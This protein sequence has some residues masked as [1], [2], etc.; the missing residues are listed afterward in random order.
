MRQCVT[1]AHAFSD[2]L[3]NDIISTLS[4]ILQVYKMF[5]S[6]FLISDMLKHFKIRNIMHSKKKPPKQMT[7]AK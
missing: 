7:P 6:S 1:A 2:D 4:C 5:R 3:Y